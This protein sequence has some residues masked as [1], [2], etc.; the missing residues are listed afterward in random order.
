VFVAEFAA[1]L[2][3]DVVGSIAVVDM[4]LGGVVVAAAAAVVVGINKLYVN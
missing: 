4:V 2:V 3:V 1:K